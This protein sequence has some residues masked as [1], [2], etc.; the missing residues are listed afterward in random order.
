MPPFLSSSDIL[1]C[2]KR[3]RNWKNG[4]TS[5]SYRS[6]VTFGIVAPPLS[7]WNS[8]PRNCDAADG[9][10]ASNGRIRL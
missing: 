3:G 8:W 2:S 7:T 4:S 5:V 6:L 10:L 9:D 1:S